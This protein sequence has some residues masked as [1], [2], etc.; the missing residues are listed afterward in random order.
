M[1]YTDAIKREGESIG[2]WCRRYFGI[3]RCDER[4]SHLRLHQ[5][6]GQRA[7]VPT[8]RGVLKSREPIAAL[9]AL[10]R[11]HMAYPAPQRHRQWPRSMRGTLLHGPHAEF[12]GSCIGRN[13]RNAVRRSDRDGMKNSLS[14]RD[15]RKSCPRPP[16]RWLAPLNGARR[17]GNWRTNRQSANPY[18]PIQ[19]LEEAD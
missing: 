11:G 9:A 8:A 16:L 5:C 7:P 6:F 19:V 3:S 12:F 15:E 10:S 18:L 4:R 14:R 2:R 13:W 1:R 17:K